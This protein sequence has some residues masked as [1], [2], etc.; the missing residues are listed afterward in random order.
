MKYKK[1]RRN[2]IG[3]NWWKFK[4][5]MQIANKTPPPFFIEKTLVSYEYLDQ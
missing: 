1:L 5:G 3:G 4:I 2:I